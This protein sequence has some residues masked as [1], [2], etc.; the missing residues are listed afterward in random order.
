MPDVHKISTLMIVPS[1]DLRVIATRHLSRMSRS[2]RALLRVID[3]SGSS[4]AELASYLL[5]EDRYTQ[6]LIALGRRDALAQ[7]HDLLSFLCSERL[8]NTIK[9]PA[10]RLET[11]S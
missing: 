6:E 4:G 7:R 2:L 8:E 11:L 5:F 10:L 1:E 9:L 3:A